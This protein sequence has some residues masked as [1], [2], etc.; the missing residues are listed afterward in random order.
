VHDAA[1]DCDSTRSRL[2][3]QPRSDGRRES[4]MG[5][6]ASFAV[7]LSTSVSTSAST[8]HDRTALPTTCSPW[9]VLLH[10]GTMGTLRQERSAGRS[11]NSLPTSGAHLRHSSLR[12]PYLRLTPQR[13]AVQIRSPPPGLTSG[14]ARFARRTSGSLLSGSQ[15]RFAPHLRGS[16]PAQ[17]A[18]LAVPP[19]HSSAGRSTDSLPTSGAHLRHSSLRS[20]YLRLTPQRVAVPST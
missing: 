2:E 7:P 10:Q 8:S 12:S 19:A 6:P 18:S 5:R 13:V 4:A 11:T 1:P 20:P 15:Y 9:E 3:P 14:T 17:L 16:P